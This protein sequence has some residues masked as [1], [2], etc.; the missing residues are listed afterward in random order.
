[1][2]VEASTQEHPALRQGALGVWDHG[3]EGTVT[4]QRLQTHTV[5]TPE[6]RGPWQWTGHL[7]RGLEGK[8]NVALTYFAQS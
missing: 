2:D 5:F 7:C 6:L 4:A 1:M 8:E 3:H